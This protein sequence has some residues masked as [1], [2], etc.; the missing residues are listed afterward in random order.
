M[1][2]DT[3]DIERIAYRMPVEALL[4]G[5]KQLLE[6]ITRGE[7]LPAILD[8][9][10][11]LV[12]EMFSGTLCS[13]L[14]LDNA[15]ER[16]WHGA[17]P[18][19]PAA[20]TAAIS[21]GH[22]GPN[23]ASCGSAAYRKQ[24]VVCADIETDPLWKDYR[25]VALMYGL[26]ACW[27]MPIFSSGGTVLGTFAVYS[28]L[29][30]S[31]SPQ[32]RESIE[33]FAHLASIA[34][35]RTRGEE[36]LRR[37][38]AYLAE[39]QRLSLTG[40]F[41]WKVE[42]GEIFWS[43][44][45]YRLLEVERGTKPSLDLVFQRVPP[46]EADWVRHVLDQ[47]IRDGADLDFQHRLL[48]PSGAVKQ[49]HVVARPTKDGT[50][51]IEYFGAVMDVTHRAVANA[52]LRASEQ[53]ARGQWV[54]LARTLDAL[55]M[56]SA[57]DRLVEHVLRTIAGQLGAHSVS[58]WRRD[59]SSGTLKF[60]C[61]FE[62]GRLVTKSEKT[63]ANVPP[64][65]IEEVWPWPEVFRTG[66]A[67]VLEDIR[68]GPPFLWREHL[69]GLGI[70]TVLVAPMLV[71]GRLAGMIGIRFTEKRAVQAQE[72]E[73]A[74]ALANQA[75]LAIQLTRLSAQSRQA[76]VVAERN[77]LAREIHD[78]LA[79]GLT[80]IILQLEATEDALTRG[81]GS[82]AGQ[83]LQ[84]AGK[85][86]REALGEARRSVQALRPQALERQDL[87]GAMETMLETMTPGTGL[88]AEL[89]VNGERRTLPDEF[90]DNLLRIAQEGLT[91]AIR[92]ARATLFRAR[93]A[94]DKAEV[95]LELSDDGCGFDPSRKSDG[96]GL[97][98]IRERVEGMGGKMSVQTG[99][100]RG[101]AI[102]IA[103][104]GAIDHSKRVV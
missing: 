104:P 56:E 39:A 59:G 53:L 92:Y 5:D 80:G 91:N 86:A 82:E 97:I 21:G 55:S 6:M 28:K 42:S 60:E 68:T 17:A 72:L 76:A 43:N 49:V 96:F 95:R 65:R 52:A 4:A 44:E 69:I 18:S 45:T 9:L 85:L 71:S 46:E 84:R 48:L 89:I 58:V 63:A 14:L 40:S 75:M 94:F 47:A 31:P 74:Q 1:R 87:C 12:E 25:D 101:A 19:L 35:E 67:T 100:G 41:G 16:L 13:V 98:G 8:A 66:K 54:S 78:T 34:I 61:A 90:E 79:Q 70:V 73:L 36:A 38:E 23:V 22:I 29:P 93:L 3:R 7:L 103:L 24:L 102:L 64:L 37:S 50:G 11:R 10:C 26:R 30:C 77:R 99:P 51:K 15:G 57:P 88:K 20:Y 33:Q 81:L 62:G 2:S 27:S 83:H 32:Q